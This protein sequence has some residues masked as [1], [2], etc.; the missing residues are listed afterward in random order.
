MDHTAQKEVVLPHAL[1]Q[2]ATV[3]WQGVEETPAYDG[4]CLS[5][6][7]SEN[8]SPLRIGRLN[9]REVLPRVRSLGLLPPG[10]PIQLFPIGKPLQV[11][12][13]IFDAKNFEK[14]TGTTREQWAEQVDQLVAIKSKRLEI[15]MQE[16]HAELLQPDYGSETLV[17]AVTNMILVELARLARTLNKQSLKRSLSVVLAPWQFRRIQERI[18]VA[19]EQGYPSLAE[20]ADICGISEGHLA[21]TFKAATGWQIHQYIADERMRVAKSMLAGNELTCEEVSVRLG[22]KSAA[23]FSTAFRR[24]SGKSPSQYRSEIQSRA[25]DNT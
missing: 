3:S 23:Y 6:R 16:I 20:L 18:Q 1:V 5:Q 25:G 13:C 14:V 11:L 10:H 21:R 7:L 17:E 15:L 12:Y 8:H 22:F 4:Y 2:L 9:A 19:P 24:V